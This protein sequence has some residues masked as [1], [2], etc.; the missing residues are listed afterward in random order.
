[1][2]PLIGLTCDR[3]VLDP[4]PFHMV[5]EKYIDAVRHGAG[6]LPLL[7]PALGDALPLPRLLELVD[8]LVFT[9][10][11]SNV[12]PEH[13]GGGEPYPGSPCD[14]QRDRTDLLLLPRALELGVPVLGICRGLQELNVALGGTLHQQVHAIEGLH[15]HRDDGDEPLAER[16]APAHDVELVP[17]GELAA[18]TDRRVWRVNSL[19]GQGI[20]RL[21][22]RLRVEARAPDGL[23]EAV[24][25][26][27]ARGFALAVQWHPEWRFAEHPFYAA[28]WRAFAAACAS[29]ARRRVA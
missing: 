26:R 24:S 4:H 13:Y 2:I 8:G 10:S 1:M 9:G 28:L 18:L 27:E 3:R 6:G 29:Y 14:P 17:D 5:G 23:I 16:Y 22:D 21:A 19:H 11:P 15:D 7:I 20:D 25:V 12:L